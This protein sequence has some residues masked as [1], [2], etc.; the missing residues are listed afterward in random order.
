MAGASMDDDGQFFWLVLVH[1]SADVAEE[2]AV[3]LPQ[4]VAETDSFRRRQPWADLIE[5]ERLE[6]NGRLWWRKSGA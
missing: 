3:L 2:K 1:E 5:I 4:R 6:V